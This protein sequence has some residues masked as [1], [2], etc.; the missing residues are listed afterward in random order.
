MDVDTSRD[1]EE[2]LSAGESGST[3]GPGVPSESVKLG[4]TE[5]VEGEISKRGL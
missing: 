2:R 5:V 3:H 4:N 1:V